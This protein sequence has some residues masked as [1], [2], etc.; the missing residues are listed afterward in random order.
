MILKSKQRTQSVV[1]LLSTAMNI[2]VGLA[3]NYYLTKI[4]SKEE[5]GN[6][7]LMINILEMGQ[8]IVNFGFYQS[9]CRLV[10]LT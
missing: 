1:L 5:Y 2:F 7:A 10:A 6:Y 3:V 9:I 8:V 4:L